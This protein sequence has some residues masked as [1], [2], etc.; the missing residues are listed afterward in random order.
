VAVPAERLYEESQPE[1][2]ISELQA[3]E[4]RALFHLVPAPEE[5]DSFELE[6]DDETEPTQAQLSDLEIKQIVEDANSLSND[7]TT[8][9]LA[10]MLKRAGRSPLLNAS[11]EVYLAKRIEL[12]DEAAKTRMIE[13]NMRLVVS[14]AKRYRSYGVEF[15]DLIQ[16]G[17]IGLI[18]AVEKFDWRKGN[19][20]STYGTWWARQ[21]VHRAIANHGRTIRTPAHV[22]ERIIKLDKAAKRLTIELGREPTQDELARETKL[23]PAYVREALSAPRTVS[24]DKPIGEDGEATLG[25]LTPDPNSM[26]DYE[27]AEINEDLRTTTLKAALA[28]LP[29]KRDRETIELRYGLVDGQL[30]TLAETAMA[31]GVTRERAR[32]R[33]IRALNQLIGHSALIDAWDD[34]DNFTEANSHKHGNTLIDDET[35]LSYLAPDSTE[36]KVTKTQQYIFDMLQKGFS[37]QQIADRTGLTHAMA[38]WRINEAYD[39][40]G[41]D[42]IGNGRRKLALNKWQ[43]LKL[44]TE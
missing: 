25:D 3:D 42:K 19:K 9:T 33:E 34:P 16:E 29:H 7:Y 10:F 32:Q 21:A 22:H 36:I 27:R 39:A 11:E 30:R 35:I 2:D 37:I 23:S 8:D 1:I 26:S 28:T 43:T 24:L 5:P 17:Y 4:H 18:R 20:F 40:L 31:T 38:K 14:I 6:E 12:G 41:I 15:E 13:S 44:A